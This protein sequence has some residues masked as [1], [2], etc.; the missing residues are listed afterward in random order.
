[1]YES[2]Y[3]PTYI[4]SNDHTLQLYSEMHNIY[5]AIQSYTQA[6]IAIKEYT[7]LIDS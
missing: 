3:V 5:T 7:G 6:Y 2:Y 4:M 1:M